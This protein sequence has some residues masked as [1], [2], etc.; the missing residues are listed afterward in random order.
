MV[1]YSIVRV[2]MPKP[3]KHHGTRS[4]MYTS[5]SLRRLGLIPWH[6]SGFQ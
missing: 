3:P 4:R 1:P 6:T 2:K 5:T